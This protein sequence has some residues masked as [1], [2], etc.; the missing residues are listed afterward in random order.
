MEKD[1]QH[2]D[3][4]LK[5][6]F[7]ELPLDIPSNDFTKLVM[8]EVVKEEKKLTTQSLPLI[9]N[10]VWGLVAAVLVALIFIPF[11]KQEGGI[12]EKVSLDFSFFENVTL[13]TYEGAAVSN[14]MLYAAVLF[15]IMMFAQVFYLKGYFDKKMSA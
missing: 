8:R 14:T 2:L 12:L 6:Q 1:N 7:K 9:S 13:P 4:L 11:K 15:S 5:D 3:Q 10:K